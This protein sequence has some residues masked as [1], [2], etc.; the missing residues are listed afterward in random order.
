MGT[1]SACCNCNMYQWHRACFWHTL[2]ISFV[3]SSPY[4]NHQQFSTLCQILFSQ[5]PCLLQGI[6]EADRPQQLTSACIHRI[7]TFATPCMVSLLLDITIPNP[8]QVIFVT[9]Y[10]SHQQPWLICFGM[11]RHAL[12]NRHCISKYY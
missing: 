4:C 11:Q 5:P 1:L 6:M 8:V 2:N 9:L 7:L 10:T 12:Y 3:N